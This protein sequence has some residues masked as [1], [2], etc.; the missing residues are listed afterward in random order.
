MS[1][2]RNSYTINFIT[3][4]LE[5]APYLIK[6]GD[7]CCGIPNGLCE[8]VN[9]IVR[10]HSGTNLDGFESKAKLRRKSIRDDIIYNILLFNFYYYIKILLCFARK[11]Y[12][13]KDFI[14]GEIKDKTYEVKD[15]IKIY[16]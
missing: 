15:K 16:L 10:S 9:N 3:S 8:F 12:Y 14:N 4:I 6:Y 7:L 13:C 1:K 5:R 11:L 2:N